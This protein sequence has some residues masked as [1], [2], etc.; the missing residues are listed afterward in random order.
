MKT[1]WLNLFALVAALV[2]VVLVVA[3]NLDLNHAHELLNV[4]YAPTG[5]LYHAINQQFVAEYAKQNGISLTVKQSHGGS[6]RQA[7]AVI[8]GLKADVVTLALPSDVESLHKQGL[9]ADGWTQRLPNNSQPYT[10]TIVFVVRKGNPKAIKDWPDLISP[11]VEVVTPNPKTS[12]NGKLSLLAAWGSVIHNGGTE[13]QAR[14][15]IKQ[16]Y[17]HVSVLGT[18]ATDSKA[19]FAYDKTGDVHLTWESEALGEVSDAKGEL[20][21]IYPSVSIRAE[22]SVAWVDANVAQHKTETYAK[23]YLQFLFTDKGQ[24]ILAKQGY[25]PFNTEILNKHLNTLPKL[26]LFPITLI[27]K[28]WDDAQAKFFADNAIFDLI[29][30]SKAN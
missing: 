26:D 2:S 27:A 22:P 9:I 8:G 23:A 12:G 13:E 15:Y 14:D 24:E 19:T 21:I 5:D 20:E 10:S 1:K 18:S 11:R 4:S 29:Y 28:D 6:A 7:K 25:R 3:R 16:L 30:K 17:Q